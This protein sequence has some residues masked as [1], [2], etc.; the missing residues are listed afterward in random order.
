MV[1]KSSLDKI[2]QSIVLPQFPWIEDYEILES[3]VESWGDRRDYYR[4]NYFVKPD[5]DGAFTVDDDFEKVVKL[6]ETL[7]KM[8]GPNKIQIFEGVEF[9]ANK[10]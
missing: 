6:T 3:R 9:Y 5:E 7:F 10:K 4:I 1:F 2:I 8:L